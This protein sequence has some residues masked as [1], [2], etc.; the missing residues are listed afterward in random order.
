MPKCLALIV[1]LLVA[2]TACGGAAEIRVENNSELDFA[3]VKVGGQ[4]FGGIA[5]GATSKYQTV[6]LKFRYALVELSAGGYTVNGQTLATGADRFTYRIEVTDLRAG[7]L[8]I[9]VIGE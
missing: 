3:D 7:H 4:P 5:A 9:D 1:L 6:D 8:A 2:T